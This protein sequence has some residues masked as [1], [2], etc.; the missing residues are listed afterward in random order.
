MHSEKTPKV[1]VCVITYNQEKYI[2]RCLQSIVDQATE[3]DFEVIV[4]EDCST[5][6]TRAIVQ[7]F[8]ERYPGIVKPMY[9]EKNIGGGV[10][11][12][13]TVHRAAQGQY[14]A[15]IDGDDYA[16]PGKLQAQANVLDFKSG[17]TAVWHRVDYFDDAG[18]FCS[19]N[20]S[21]LSQFNSGKVHFDEAI[22][23]GFIGVHSSLMYRRSAREVIHVDQKVLDLYFTWDLLSKGSGY[24][25]DEVLGRYRIAASGS[26]TVNASPQICRLAIKHAAHFLK[27][28]PEQ[29][30]NFFIWAI[31]N[32]IFDV[33]N[34]RLT[35][36]N[37][38]MFAL[39]S[40]AFVS[41]REIL[42]NVTNIRKIQV[43][44]SR[45]TISD[46]SNK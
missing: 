33:K 38:L 1:T 37:Y 12:F 35:V 6:G 16:L 21:E 34:G 24:I 14:V 44:W 2:R 19:G 17:C 30:K 13:L 8:A 20:T 28:N 40:I 7:E 25:L 45:K 39:K 43:R 22:R 18:G 3:F 23:L 5:D 27:K 9:Q 31:T 15:H 46:L 41:P 11:N 10:Y 36:F 4:G 32:A 29:R 26:L 42:I